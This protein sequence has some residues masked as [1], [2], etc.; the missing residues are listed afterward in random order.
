MN[1]FKL[2]MKKEIY[3]Y[4]KVLLKRF[5]KKARNF[6]NSIKLLII[7]DTHGELELDDKYIK[8]FKDIDY[9][10]CCILGD[11]TLKE[12][13]IIKEY[14]PTDKIL[15]LL[16]NHDSLDLLEKANLNNINGKVIN[17]KG[18]RIAGIQGTYKY[19]DEKFPSFTHEESKNFLDNMPEVDI[20]L[21]HDK[22][23][24][25]NHKNYA[26]D[27]LQGITY[28]LYKN[29]IPI[30]IHGHLHESY[31]NVLKNGTTEKCVY[32]IEIIDIQNGKII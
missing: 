13:E 17:Y 18:L 26:H 2:F 8:K 5:K 31:E 19:K 23:F 6:N 4:E 32:R 10:L 30:N 27:G 12:Y 1:L 21:S 11:V 25:I 7:S 22:P 14:I 29:Q 24:T 15:A 3:D 28:Y 16:G 9:D 20:L